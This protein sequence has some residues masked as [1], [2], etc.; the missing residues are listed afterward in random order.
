ML[1]F[2]LFGA[3][4]A[5]YSGLP[6]SHDGYPSRGPSRW[7][8]LDRREWCFALAVMFEIKEQDHAAS[9][10]YLKP[11][12]AAEVAQPRCS[13][14]CRPGCVAGLLEAAPRRSNAGASPQA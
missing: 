1:R 5:F 14:Q 8:Y 2:G 12:V 7:L 3:A 10:R 11:I 13:L 6:P 9:V 4:H